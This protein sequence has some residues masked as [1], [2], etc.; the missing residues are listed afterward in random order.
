MVGRWNFLFEMGAIVFFGQKWA[1]QSEGKLTPWGPGGWKCAGWNGAVANGA[2]SG[3]SLFPT[4]GS[5]ITIFHQQLREN[6]LSIFF[7][8]PNS[9]KSNWKLS[10]K[11]K[12][13]NGITYSCFNRKYH[14]Q[15]GTFFFDCCSQISSFEALEVFRIFWEFPS[16]QATRTFCTKGSLQIFLLL[17]Q[18]RCWT[19]RTSSLLILFSSNLC[20]C[21]SFSN[22]GNLR[23]PPLPKCQPPRK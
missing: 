21:V 19:N 7:Q 4:H 6:I 11:L 8:P 1:F 9:H 16:K 14:L 3:D 10:G 5:N 13:C 15:S 23:L 12:K 18:K 22:N 2:V 20:V 17:L